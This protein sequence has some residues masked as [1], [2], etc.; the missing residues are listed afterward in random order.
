MNCFNELHQYAKRLDDKR[1]QEELERLG[2][3]EQEYLKRKDD[4]EAT[5]KRKHQEMLNRLGITEKE[6]QQRK[7]KKEARVGCL[8][9]LLTPILF[10]LPLV[11][12]MC[13][14]SFIFSIG[15]SDTLLKGVAFI[16][17]G[18][19]A[20][21]FILL[22]LGVVYSAHGECEETGG[23]SW[24]IAAI[25]LLV[26]FGCLATNRCSHEENTDHIHYERFHQ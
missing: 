10:A 12:V 9:M 2:I 17:I 25:F 20:G 6:Y 7:E 4:I 15:I 23:T 13:I 14:G 21:A 3:T 19:F 22:T 11:L 5:K 18:G 8:Y 26:F 1:H 16:Y 24:I